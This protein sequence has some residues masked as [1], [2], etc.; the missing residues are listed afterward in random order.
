MKIL[1]ID[2]HKSNTRKPANNLHWQNANILANH[3]GADFIWSYEGVNDNIKSGYDKIIFVHASRYAFISTQWLDLSPRA[4]LFYITNEYNLGEPMLLWSVA[5]D[6]RKY[7]VIANHE[8]TP[9]KI[10]I[11]YVDKW[12]TED[13]NSLCY[14]P[15]EKMKFQ[16]ASLFPADGCVYYGSFRK[17]RIKYFLK[18]LSDPLVR[19]STSSKNLDRFEDLDVKLYGS[20][21]R[22]DWKGAGLSHFRSSLYIEDVITHTNYNYLANRFYEALNFDVV[23]LFDRSCLNTLKLSGLKDYEDYILDG[24]SDIKDKGRLK[25]GRDWHDFAE[26]NRSLCLHRLKGIIT[27]T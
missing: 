3:L 26:A 22:L 1:I 11:K 18:Y 5:K 8:P 21:A 14:N 27:G 7:T 25:V 9:S 23:P 17:G 16:Q 15:R 4:D 20:L 19:L 24:P 10:V 6:G 2:S 13:I 12:I